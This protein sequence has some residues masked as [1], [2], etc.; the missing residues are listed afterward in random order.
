MST[1][2]YLVVAADHGLLAEVHQQALTT[3]MIM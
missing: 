1:G 3:I 2:V